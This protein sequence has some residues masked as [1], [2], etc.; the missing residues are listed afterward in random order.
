[1]FVFTPA[2]EVWIQK[3]LMTKKHYPGLWDVSACGGICSGEDVAEAAAREQEEELGIKFPLR[4]IEKFTI[5][6]PDEENRL[7][8]RRLAHLF[9]GVTE[10]IPQPNDEV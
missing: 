4:F 1:M 5:T 8:R 2:G 6:M 10:E 3:R 9:M 7:V